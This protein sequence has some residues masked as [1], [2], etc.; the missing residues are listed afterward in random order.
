MTRNQRLAVLAGICVSLLFLS[1]AFNQLQPQ[2]VLRYV[3]TAQPLW[4]AAGVLALF[5]SIYV[6]AWR[7]GFILAGI[8]PIDTPTLFKLVNMTYMGNNLYPLRAG[9]AL[10]IWLMQRDHGIPLAQTTT[11]IIVERIF[12]G[13]L[14]LLFVLIP[15]LLLPQLA[16]SNIR[17]S[18][19]VLTPIFIG[20]TIAF[21]LLVV[22]PQAMRNLI[23]WIAARVPAVLG[24]FMVK[25]TDDVLG[26]MVSLRTPRFLLGA[27]VG[28]FGTWLLHAG[29]FWCVALAFGVDASLWVVLL[30][31]GMVNLA[32]ALPATPGQFG[33]F[34]Y[35]AQL[36][37][38]AY[39]ID[40][41]KAFAVALVA[42]MV[43]WLPPTLLGLALL[44][45]RGLRFGDVTTLAKG[46]TLPNP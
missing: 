40:S 7:W 38:T 37:F 9:E 31:A 28:T 12:D 4:L 15:S 17:T 20:V 1:F 45:Q 46:G 11:T 5:A 34:E 18:T 27:I 13:L 32:G 2:E 44:L 36:A 16:L 26:G 42:H 21:T 35:F 3:V 23:A 24:K 19:L 43:I 25:I 30:A 14:M 8:K 39:G 10:R 33:T 41:T 22:Y 6:I 29:V